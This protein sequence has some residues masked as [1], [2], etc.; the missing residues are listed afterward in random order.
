ML[1]MVKILEENPNIK[2]GG[3]EYLC[4]RGPGGKVL[5]CDCLI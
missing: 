3:W 1:D 5:A 4:S 2:V